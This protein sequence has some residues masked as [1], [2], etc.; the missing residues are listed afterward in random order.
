MSYNKLL[1]DRCTVKRRVYGAADVTGQPVETWTDAYVN[2]KCR[3]TD[4]I[5]FTGVQGYSYYEHKRVDTH[6]HLIFFPNGTLIRND[7]RIT[8]VVYA[9]G[10]VHDNGPFDVIEVRAHSN[11][12]HRHHVE[13]M[14][15]RIKTGGT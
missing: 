14:L 5:S 10:S 1:I 12:K 9:D 13:C 4:Q 6:D 11:S 3:L 8:D 15:K 7:D 2:Q